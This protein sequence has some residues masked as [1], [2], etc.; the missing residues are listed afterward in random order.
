VD[1]HSL[2]RNSADFFM[3]PSDNIPLGHIPFLL[4][5]KNDN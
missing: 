2:S 4:V 3:A 5:A 1:I